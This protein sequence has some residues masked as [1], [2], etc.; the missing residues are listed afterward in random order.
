MAK[1]LLSL[2]GFHSSPA[3]L[4]ARQLDE[5][6]KENHPE[7]TFICPQLPS[8]PGQMWE[9]IDA[10]FEQYCD[11]DIAVVGSSLGGY[12]ATKVAQHYKCRVI[13]VNPAVTP[14]RLLQVYEGI[15]THPYTG[16]VYQIDNDYMQQL[17]ALDV[18]NIEQPVLFWVLIQEGDEVLDY[19]QAMTKYQGCKIS[20]EKAGDHSFIGFE[21]YIPDIIKFLF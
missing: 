8:L 5:Y 21:R 9:L 15:Q 20:C 17:K 11:D 6:I 3:S 14:Y 13:L 7:I 1:I 4:K 12:L 18:T 16:D 10:I 2:H 19:R